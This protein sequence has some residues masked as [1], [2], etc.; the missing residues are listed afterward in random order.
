MK[1][2]IL[3]VAF[4]ITFFASAQ[5]QMG[6]TDRQK[7]T[8]FSISSNIL[9]LTIE[10]GGTKTVDLTPYLGGAGTDN[11]QLSFNPT[12]NIL[13]LEN[14]GTVD[15]S[16]VLD[17]KINVNPV[18]PTQWIAIAGGTQAELDAADLLGNTPVGGTTFAFPTDL[19]ATTDGMIE[20]FSM[21]IVGTDTLQFT[22]NYPSPMPDIVKKVKLPSVGG[23]GTVDQ[24]LID[25]STNAVSGNAVFDG[26]ATKVNSSD[27]N[28][29]ILYP[30]HKASTE[31]TVN[32]LYDEGVPIGS[33]SFSDDVVFI[34]QYN[35]TAT[36]YFLIKNS[37]SAADYTVFYKSISAS[38][39]CRIYGGNGN[40]FMFLSI[41][42]EI[43]KS[44]YKVYKVTGFN[45]A[46]LPSWDAIVTKKMY[47]FV[48]ER[49]S[50][51]SSGIT[52]NRPILPIAGQQYFDITLNLPIW[53]NGT[54]W[55]DAT[56]T[57]R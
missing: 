30:L 29:D 15:L 16:T 31:V 46:F 19:S 37:L 52:A 18:S 17:N 9:S 33:M 20:D 8:D 56:G 57:T 34:N 14:G 38:K 49:L 54:N 32:V 39:K 48:E 4:F 7:I 1:K 47:V 40:T 50:D 12:N 53:Y 42:N 13:T 41:T 5:V 26:L 28:Y 24:T 2:H 44:G 3:I 25:G 10:N 6:N 45:G 23:G 43:T 27:Y 55:V 36:S 22:A 51:V 21:A 35:N 11:Q